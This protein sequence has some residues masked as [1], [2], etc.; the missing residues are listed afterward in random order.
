VFK[1][2]ANGKETVLHSFA[3]GAGGADPH[4]GLIRDAA[5]NVYSV[6]VG[7]G[8]SNRGT[9]FKLD[10]NGQETVLYTF[11]GG[12][13]GGFSRRLADPGRSR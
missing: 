9:V 1:L 8:T 12:A 11:T 6:T 5:G 7:G 3:G 10:T 2:D 4:A 13:D